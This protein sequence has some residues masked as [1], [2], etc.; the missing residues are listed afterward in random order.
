M[1][2]NQTLTIDQ[3]EAGKTYR[4]C[5]LLPSGKGISFSDIVFDCCEFEKQR[6]T[7]S[8]W[9]DCTFKNSVFSN[10][11]FSDSV[12]YRCSFNH[13]QLLGTNFSHNRWK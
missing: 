11:D 3:L 9:L 4:N 1:I 2:E 10:Q 5:R 6:F 13:C 7:Y 8:E 12:F